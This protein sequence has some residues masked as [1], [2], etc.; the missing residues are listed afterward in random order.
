MGQQIL[1]MMRFLFLLCLC[2]CILATTAF[3]AT[4]APAPWAFQPLAAGYAAGATDPTGAL[5]PGLISDAARA[6]LAAWAPVLRET[7]NRLNTAVLYYTHGEVGAEDDMLAGLLACGIQPVCGTDVA[8]RRLII[9]AKAAQQANVRALREAV[10]AGAVLCITP[11]ADPAVAKAFNADKQLV[12]DQRCMFSNVVVGRGYVQ[13]LVCSPTFGAPGYRQLLHDLLQRAGVSEEFGFTGSDGFDPRGLLGFMLES[14]DGTQ[15]YL[16]AVAQQ[17]VHARLYLN[18]RVNGVRDLNAGTTLAWQPPAW[19][20]DPHGRYIE[21]SL[22]QGDVALLALLEETPGGSVQVQPAQYSLGDEPTLAVQVQR[23]DADGHPAPRTHVFHVALRGADG[24]TP[25]GAQAYATGPSP[26]VLLLPVTAVASGRWRLVADDLTDGAHAE[27]VIDKRAP[28]APAPG[29]RLSWTWP[30][31]MVRGRPLPAT[32]TLTAS[33]A[34]A[35]L[36]HFPL[37][38]C[39]EPGVAVSIGKPHSSGAGTLAVPF[40]FTVPPAT[41]AK[42]I[43]FCLDADCQVLGGAAL[44]LPPAYRLTLD[45]LPPLAPGAIQATL[46]G[47]VVSSVADSP[48]LAIS[49]DIPAS[50]VISGS[51]RFTVQPGK[52][53]T[54]ALFSVTVRVRGLP[55]RIAVAARVP[56]F[57]P[58]RGEWTLARG[59]SGAGLQALPHIPDPLSQ[60]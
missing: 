60:R 36:P 18:P 22:A 31:A 49:L 47:A 39:D 3:A 57:A 55:A 5:L 8:G 41:A 32:L 43:F 28:G 48:T 25:D 30:A 37:V 35:A 17:A 11:D 52:P 42:A 29:V 19:E 24:S 27:C 26:Q 38:F 58:L 20:A 1:A 21:L 9:A 4:A 14:A 12:G 45:P 50:C 13:Y 44:A 34:Q 59:D 15:A 23:V 46:R 53:G 33:D 7:H 2:L 54:P 40:S 51:R 56:G 16:V 10:A 6:R